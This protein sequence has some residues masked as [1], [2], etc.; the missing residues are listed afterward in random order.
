MWVDPYQRLFPRLC[1]TE[2]ENVYV[3]FVMRLADLRCGVE[4]T[5]EIETVR[6]TL[7]AEDGTEAPAGD[8]VSALLE[9]AR[10]ACLDR[11]EEP[12]LAELVESFHAFVGRRGAKPQ[13]EGTSAPANPARKRFAFLRSRR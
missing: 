7:R 12:C 5:G 4:A 3:D 2:D 8:V 13:A 10:A 6:E 11:D 9:M 1:L